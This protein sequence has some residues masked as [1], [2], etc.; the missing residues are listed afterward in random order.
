MRDKRLKREL[1]DIYNSKST[2]RY[3]LFLATLFYENYKILKGSIHITGFLVGFYSDNIIGI[4]QEV[5]SSL[6]SIGREYI[7]IEANGKSFIDCVKSFTG[8][9]YHVN[10]DAFSDLKEILLNGNK[11]IVFKEFSKSKIRTTKEKCLMARSIIKIYDSVHLQDV[12]PLSDLIFIDYAGFL[13]H[14]WDN[15]GAYL[16]VMS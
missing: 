2:N 9:D 14:C 6:K 7:I 5:Q 1:Y 11:V 15:I 12:C 13:Q 8:K 10:H 4:T 3:K 16:K